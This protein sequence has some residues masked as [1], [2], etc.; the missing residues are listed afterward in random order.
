[1]QAECKIVHVLVAIATRIAVATIILIV[2]HNEITLFVC[3]LV[4]LL[5]LFMLFAYFLLVCYVYIVCFLCLFVCLIYYL[6]IVII[7]PCIYI[8]ISHIIRR[9]IF[10]YPRKN[11]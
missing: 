3:L 5:C 7:M 11:I 2:P 6:F 10:I 4:C 1:M 9:D 8:F